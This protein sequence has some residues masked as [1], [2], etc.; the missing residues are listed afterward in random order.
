MANYTIADIQEVLVT[1]TDGSQFIYKDKGILSLKRT[2]NLPITRPHREVIVIN[3]E[4][5]PAEEGE[6]LEFEEEEDAP[7]PKARARGPRRQAQERP[8]TSNGYNMLPLSYSAPKGGRTPTDIA[9]E[10]QKEAEATSG[11]RY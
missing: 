6:A 10:L 8:P 11:V 9:R 2:L 1:L 3:T 5:D 4:D 7:P